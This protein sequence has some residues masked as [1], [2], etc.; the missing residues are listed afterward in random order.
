MNGVPPYALISVS[1]KTG[2]VE[3]AKGLQRMNKAILSTGG[4]AEVLREAGIDVVEVSDYTGFPEIMDGRIKTLL[5][6]ILGGIL[7]RPSIDAVVMQRHRM[8][9][10]N[11]IV[12]NLYPFERTIR[13]PKCTLEQAVEK[14]DIGGPTILRSAAKNHR[15]ATAIVNPDR[16]TSVLTEMEALGGSVSD[17]TRLLL[18]AE[19]FEHVAGYDKIIADY[20]WKV[21][22]SC[23]T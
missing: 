10:I 7:G 18:A 5:P 14:I 20:L 11:L 23:V 8:T 2:I 13:D 12:C 21:S 4:T 15:F 17:R 19:V 6:I 22:E 3:F 1:D 16:Y 9:P